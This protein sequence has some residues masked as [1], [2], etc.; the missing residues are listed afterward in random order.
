MKD[1]RKLSLPF[2]NLTLGIKSNIKKYVQECT[3]YQQNKVQ[4]MKKT[5]EL[6]PLEILKRIIGPLLRSNDKDTIVD[7]FTKII[8]LKAT[9]MAVSLEEIA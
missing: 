2:V 8:R 3:K 5:E 1:K 7:L 6:H 9:T 4:H